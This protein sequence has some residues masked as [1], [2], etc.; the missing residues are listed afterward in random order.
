LDDYCVTVEPTTEGLPQPGLLH[1]L[2]D[3][4]DDEPDFG[5]ND[6]APQDV[7]PRKKPT[8]KGKKH[9]DCVHKFAAIMHDLKGDAEGITKFYE[10]MCQFQDRRGREHVIIKAGAPEF[11]RT[12]G[13]ADKPK[14]TSKPKK[15]SSE[16]DGK[17]KRK[18]SKI[19]GISK[20]EVSRPKSE[21][22][23][24]DAAILYLKKHGARIGW[25]LECYN[26]KTPDRWFMR[27][28]KGSTIKDAEG[29]TLIKSCV[30]MKANSITVRE[31]DPLNIEPCTCDIEMVKAC[32]T[33]NFFQDV[34]PP[35]KT[36]AAITAQ[37]KISQPPATKWDP[38]R[39]GWTK[40]GSEAVTPGSEQFA[41]RTKA[42]TVGN[43]AYAVLRDAMKAAQVPG[44]AQ[45]KNKDDLI[46]LMCVYNCAFTALPHPAISLAQAAV[47]CL[48]VS[49][50][51]SDAPIFR[52]AI[53]MAK[54]A[55]ANAKAAS[56]LP[57]KRT[58]DVSS[59]DSDAPISRGAIRLA[60]EAAANAKAASTL[61]ANKH[62]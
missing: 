7:H 9:N 31:T 36:S 49:S 3:H 8:N 43:V 24:G 54:E 46:K 50:S 47:T 22:Y 48:N 5:T 27:V 12:R 1:Q 38:V 60:K 37:K 45:A 26:N 62:T 32:G 61:P 23:E 58:H 19:K 2:G 17:P 18:S 30:W 53:R 20:E 29:N 42:L 33:P 21:F 16:S 11:V 28:E 13:R 56:T 25:I 14:G 57:A 4:A 52:G 44:S 40:H 51:D 10:T 39:I 35:L 55:A 15:T 6:Y 34:A 59:S 41:L